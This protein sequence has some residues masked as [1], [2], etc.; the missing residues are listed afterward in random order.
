MSDELRAILEWRMRALPTAPPKSV[1]S[2]CPDPVVVYTDAQGEGHCAAVL[3]PPEGPGVRV[4]HT[5]IPPW[6]ADLD[7]QECGIFEKELLGAA[8]G[9]TIALLFP[10]TSLL[11]YVA[12]IR[13]QL[14]PLYG[15]RVKH[16]WGC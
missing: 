2:R 5:H 12:T 9:V 15:V 6:M 10:P 8:L 16:I 1:T 11:S 4:A 13:G 7:E 3:F 14:G